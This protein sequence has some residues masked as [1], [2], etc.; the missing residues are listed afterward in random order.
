MGG[1]RFR[2]WDLREPDNIALQLDRRGNRGVV[3]MVFFGDP[4]LR[5]P[6]AR[7]FG[8]LRQ[9]AF[10]AWPA[11]VACFER[12]GLLAFSGRLQR[13]LLGFRVESQFARPDGAPCALGPYD[14][15]RAVLFV[16]RLLNDGLASCVWG[17]F[18][19]SALFTVR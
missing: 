4:I 9:R 7:G 6:R 5:A 11:F 18:P 10:D 2:T 19:R 14:T 17:W 13:S 3:Q 8:R 12:F 15:S 16:K 1:G